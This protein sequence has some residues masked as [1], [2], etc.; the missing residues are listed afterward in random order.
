MGVKKLVV[1]GKEVL[2]PRELSP[3]EA[4][5]LFMSILRDVEPEIARELE[6]AELK[7]RVE[8]EVL[9]IYRLSAVF[10]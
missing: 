2:L 3:E 10:G 9:V 6:G 1:L 7:A 8:G 5:K 4:E